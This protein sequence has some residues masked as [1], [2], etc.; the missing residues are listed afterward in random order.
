MSKCLLINLMSSGSGYERSRSIDVA[1]TPRH[2]SKSVHTYVQANTLI[3]ICPLQ[4]SDATLTFLSE[5]EIGFLAKMSLPPPAGEDGR[6][7]E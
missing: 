5:D 3:G 1:M 7:I 6:P 4:L 2:F